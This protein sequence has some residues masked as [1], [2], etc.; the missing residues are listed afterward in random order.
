[1]AGCYFELKS[2]P[3]N[4][5]WKE[6]PWFSLAEDELEE[7]GKVMKTDPSDRIA[8]AV[9]TKN[10]VWTMESGEA[11]QVRKIVAGMIDANGRI[12]QNNFSKGSQ[13]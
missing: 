3:Y 11:D 2:S 13:S 10:M 7:L 5:I 8:M 9:I 1:M 12:Y 6:I 4:D